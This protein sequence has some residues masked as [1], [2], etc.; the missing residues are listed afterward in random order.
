MATS[1]VSCRWLLLIG[2]LLSIGMPLQASNIENSLA[3]Q[4]LNRLDYH[5]AKTPE[6]ALELIE[7]LKTIVDQE[8]KSRLV[9]LDTV[10]CWN[11]FANTKVQKERAIEVALS[12]QGKYKR[13]SQQSIHL[14]LRLCEASFLSVNTPLD[15]VVNK[16]TTLIDE[17]YLINKP[18]LAAKGKSLRGSIFSFQGNYSNALDDL[19][20]AQKTFVKNKHRYWQNA[21]LGELAATYRRFGDAQSALDYQ[22]QLEKNYQAIGQV[23]EANDV[24][25]Q[26]A[27]SLEKLGQQDKAI[28]RYLQSERFLKENNQ[29]IYAA[30]ISVTI[31]GIL[32]EQQH[33]Q[34]GLDRLLAAKE[35]ILPRFS[36]PYSYLT[37]YLAKAYYHLENYPQS[38]D[39]LNNAEQIF[40][41]DDNQRGLEK[42]ALLKSKIYQGMQDWQKA[43]QVLSSYIND[44]L[45]ADEA[46]NSKRNEQMKARFHSQKIQLENALLIQSTQEQQK[47]LEILASQDRMRLIIIALVAVILLVVSLFALFQVNSKRRFKQLALTD[48]LTKLSNR[49][50]IN[51]FAQEQL[52]E[53]LQQGKG[54][55][56][57]S[58]D[59]DHFKQVND[60]YGHATGDLVLKAIASIANDTVRV[61]DKLGRIGGEEFLIILPNCSLEQAQLVAEA[62]IDNIAQYDWQQIASGLSQTVSAG[63]VCALQEVADNKSQQL[64]IGAQLSSLLVK[65][66]KALYLAKSS[67]R[68]CAKLAA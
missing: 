56:I 46:I 24:N 65:A 8:D 18:E 9:R 39:A 55:C 17:A 2:M 4:I 29:L 45:T 15:Q 25:I 60:K 42:A 58:F 14:D 36:A 49:R 23:F 34:E 20:S 51:A 16:L 38:L 59:A 26:I 64:T 5:R 21:N 68:N 33:Y 11:Q 37:L 40:H 47:Q 1:A 44:H 53:T 31:A 61:G 30:D 48:E 50:D 7:Q 12:L 63:I 57:I 19:V 27:S 67:G 66:D 43:Y 22:L 32:I 35:V 41:S 28:S 13:Q 10:M 3:D 54:L 6:I 52:K 62:L